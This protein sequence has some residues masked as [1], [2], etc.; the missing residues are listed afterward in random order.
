MADQT[1]PWTDLFREGGGGIDLR[2]V[3]QD[4]DA[5]WIIAGL[6]SVEPLAARFLQLLTHWIGASVG[7]PGGKLCLCCNRRV[8]GKK[9]PI[10]PAFVMALARCATPKAGILCGICPHCLDERSDAQLLEEVQ[11][12]LRRN[13]A[14]DLRALPTDSI[15]PHEP[16]N[17]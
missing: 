10:P 4:R 6:L 12:M 5:E 1:N 15:T 11:R 9:I 2:I 16:G 13:G 7:R 14:T 17:A 8:G 3:R